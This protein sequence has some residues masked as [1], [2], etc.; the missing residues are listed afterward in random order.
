MSSIAYK[1]PRSKPANSVT[2]KEENPVAVSAPTAVAPVREEVVRWLLTILLSAGVYWCMA[3]VILA[4]YHPDVAAIKKA[5]DKMFFDVGIVR[6]EPVEA[7]LFKVAVVSLFPLLAGF[8]TLLLRTPL[9][10]RLAGKVGY[11]AIAG[12]CTIAVTALTWLSFAAPNPF[13]PANGFWLRQ[14][15]NRDFCVSNF[16]FYFKGLFLENRMWLY[17]LLI[18]PLVSLLFFYGFRKKAWHKEKWFK[19]VL[20]VVTY[21]IVVYTL[22]AIIVMHSFS[23]PHTAE[24]KFDFNAVYYSMTQAYAGVPMLVDKYMNTYGLY[25]HFLVPIFKVIGLSISS[26][27]FVMALLLGCAFVLNYFF[28]RLFVRNRLLLVLGFASVIFFP[29]L[30]FKWLTIFDCVFALYPIRYIAPSL[31]V[32]LAARYF[33][34]PSRVQYYVTFFVVAALVL[35]NPEIG[36]V[37]FLSW[38]AAVCYRDFFGQGGQL[39]LS[40]V[41]GHCAVAVTALTSVFLAYMAL[42]RLC[43][44]AWPDMW[45]MFATA[46]Y[47]GVFGVGCLPM[48][49]LHPWNLSAFVLLLGFV[50]SISA[51][52]RKKVTVRST[53]ILLVSMIGVGYFVYYQGRSHNSNFALSSAFSWILLVILADDAWEQVC[54]TND[55][56]FYP[57]FILC[58][59]FLSFS[60]IELLADV[61]VTTALMYQEQDRQRARQEQNQLEAETEFINANSQEGEKIFVF[62]VKKYQ[63]ILFDGHKRVSGFN[64]GL[65]D[66][67][68]RTDIHR[69]ERVVADSNFKIFAARSMRLYDYFYGLAATIASNYEVSKVSHMFALL[70]KTKR[71]IPGPEFFNGRERSLI[72]RKYGRDTAG[73]RRRVADADSIKSVALDSAFSVE[74]LFFS[75]AQCMEAPVIIGNVVDSF[76][77]AIGK[78]STRDDVYYAAVNNKGMMVQV[79]YNSWVYVVA[80]ITP[81]FLEVYVNG[82]L[83]A[84]QVNKG[85]IPICKGPVRVG[86]F[87]NYNYF[88][89]AIGEVAVANSLLSADAVL[90]TWAQISRSL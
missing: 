76:G 78:I 82:R 18:V 45:L 89:G 53:I 63:G 80:N 47:F 72:H 29:F 30:N 41:G 28:M 21:P 31:T 71:N 90:N 79:P 37:C 65:M 59:F 27:S 58:L 8:Y 68:L 88:V 1:K 84:R 12:A 24:N 25:P 23:F 64:P 48:R 46:R 86:A 3:Q 52:V 74:A 87:K 40:K 26:F 9:A 44:G 33:F 7:L 56:V 34:R 2:Q 32:F 10:G 13:C 85:G 67:F 39:Q 49:L 61:K 54:R 83:V 38:T 14:E 11:A 42:V 20:S 51:W 66:I 43:Y 75:S 19:I 57:A 5:A 70:E 4:N 16:D 50:Y 15:N 73:M 35:W 60:W 81:G 69:M 36:L 55:G 17:S 22:F 62:T 77:F 6:P